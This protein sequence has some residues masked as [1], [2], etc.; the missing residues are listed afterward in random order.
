MHRVFVVILALFLATSCARAGS[1]AAGSVTPL[2][3][4]PALKG[5]YF[6]IDSQVV[7]RPFHIYV[8]Y[9][10]DYASNHERR[11]PVVYL[12][13]GDSLFPI[14]AT[15]HLFLTD[16]EQ[17]PEAIVVGIAYGSFDPAINRR[18]VDFIGAGAEG[19]QRFL[20]SELL[21]LVDRRYRTD[22]QRRILFGQSRGGSF[23]LHSAFTDPDLFWGRIAS[24]PGINADRER[25][26]GP[27]PTATRTD[28]RL[29][30]ASGSRDRPATRESS[31]EWF[32]VWRSRPKA[33]WAIRTITVEGGTHAANS[34][35]A[36]RAGLLWMFGIAPHTAAHD[37]H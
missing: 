34:T 2:D 31:V 4:L 25:F 13:D 18:D 7:R 24:N 19:F 12:L 8:R 36:Y 23:V 16:D 9:P 33:P 35:D 17:L 11:Y 27:A 37:P 22:P 28:L 21:P 15:S 5:D 3:Y 14:L 20:R 10:E 32:E 1:L 6:R 30:V 26:F 29:V